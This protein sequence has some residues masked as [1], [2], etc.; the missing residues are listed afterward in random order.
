[1]KRREKTAAISLRSKLQG[2]NLKTVVAAIAVG[3]ILIMTSSFFMSFFSLVSSGQTTAKVMAEN[4][5]AALMFNNPA[6]ARTILS[7]L[8]HVKSAT[9]AAFYGQDRQI[10]AKYLSGDQQVPNPLTSLQPALHYS[11]QAIHIVQPVIF[12]EQLLGAVYLVLGLRMLYRQMALQILIAAAAAL[13]ALGAA[14]LLLRRLSNAIVNPLN[15]LSG[16]MDRISDKNDFSVRAE[17]ISD[18]AE[19]NVLAQGFNEMLEQINERDIRLAGNRDRLEEEVKERTTEL[20]KAKDA[21]EAASRAKSAFLATMSHEIRTPLNGALGMTELILQ[22]ELSPEQR[23]F[24]ETAYRSGEN[25]LTII[26]DILDFSKIE[27]GKMELETIDF[28][29]AQVA[30]EVMEILAESAH[31][32]GIEVICNIH[33]LLPT[34]VMGDR[35]RLRQVLTNLVGNAI[36]FTNQ[37]QVTLSLEPTPRSTKEKPEV[38]FTIQ[39]TG[40]G[41][42]TDV[43]PN[44]F[45]PFH[46]ADSTHAR[47][48]GGTGLGLAI[49]R[50]LVMLMGGHM[51]ASSTPGYG[52]TF[53]FHVPFAPSKVIS[54]ALKLPYYL[55]GLRVLSV[56]DNE[57]N[58]EILKH[59]LQLW[60]T[61]SE[62][63]GN[64]FEALQ[65]LRSAANSDN[66][67]DLAILDMNMPG[68]NGIELAQAIK[69][70]P[71]IASIRLIMLTS[72]FSPK[73]A[74]LAREAGIMVYLTKPAKQ[75]QLH[76]AILTVYKASKTPPDPVPIPNIPHLFQADI[77]LA[78]DNEVNQE[79]ASATLEAIGC[80]VDLATNGLQVLAAIEK[81]HYDL[82]LMDI[83]MPEMDGYEATRLIRLKEKAGGIKGVPIIAVTANAL[84]GDRDICLNTGMDDFLSKPF[85][86]QELIAVLERWL[87]GSHPG[88]SHE[89]ASGITQTDGLQSESSHEKE[90]EPIIDETA[91]ESIRAMSSNPD[92]LKT[93]IG[94]YIVSARELITSIEKGYAH[95]DNEL[96]I[97]SA[98]TLKSSSSS[99][100]VKELFTLAKFIE[101]SARQG[102]ADA[103]LTKISDLG[104]AFT[105]AEQALQNILEVYPC[106]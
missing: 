58:R 80:R 82:I 49:V 92:L 86:L 38:L 29:P 70:E 95:N 81:K 83:Q 2:I 9:N 103:A 59:Q 40:I 18:I 61:R 7:T 31:S 34:S 69:K 44:L 30:E 104:Q 16:L 37:G 74:T 54:V 27:A 14:Y 52:S 64:G 96:V 85:R 94:K 57:T 3:T 71:K 12:N 105:K 39:D 88:N 47:R 76:Q 106:R 45:K 33:P 53:R 32:K 97:R 77:L 93:V 48:F 19:I 75:S 24:A 11:I 101:S 66:P 36:K 90:C 4:A 63:A 60:G 10:F 1:L 62:G 55:Q 46:Q 51:E 73:D 84:P 43:L 26:N 42:A 20:L 50:Q 41:I 56:D 98:H 91:L 5:S 99:L 72:Q 13:L 8:S 78:E 67:F 102:S 65:K 87:T 79:V 22:T 100:G 15:S 17:Y 68:Q 21:A 89:T 25:L 28:D 35:I 23:R 6:S